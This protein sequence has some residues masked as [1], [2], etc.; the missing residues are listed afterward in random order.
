MHITTKQPVCMLYYSY[1][2]MFFDAPVATEMCS[3]CIPAN[4]DKAGHTIGMLEY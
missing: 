2:N 3:V 4:M 1:Y